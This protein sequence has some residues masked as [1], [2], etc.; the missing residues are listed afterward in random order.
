MVVWNREGREANQ[1]LSQSDTAKA[2]LEEVA[3]AG[4]SGRVGFFSVEEAYI[5]E[6]GLGPSPK[7]TTSKFCN[8]RLINVLICGVKL[9]V[10]Q[11]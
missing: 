4:V 10:F 5:W 11:S 8:F 2:A 3:P 1:R 9:V 7:C 6:S